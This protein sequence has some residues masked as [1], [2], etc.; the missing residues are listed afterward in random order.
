MTKTI[1]DKVKELE[2]KTQKRVRNNAIIWG[3][4]SLA[5]YGNSAIHLNVEGNGKAAIAYALVGTLFAINAVVH[6]K[7]YKNYKEQ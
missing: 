1:E 7:T 6:Y 2:E 5:L 3:F 4:G